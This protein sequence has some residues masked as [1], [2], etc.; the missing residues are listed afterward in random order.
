MFC[1]CFVSPSSFHHAARA[2]CSRRRVW[3]AV[4]ITSFTAT[5][6]ATKRA[7]EEAEAAHRRRA[8]AARGAQRSE[9]PGSAGTGGSEREARG[10]VSGGTYSNAI[11]PRFVRCI[12]AVFFFVCQLMVSLVLVRMKQLANTG[13]RP[14]N[15]SSLFLLLFS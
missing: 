10:M 4:G 14:V 12:S 5:I 13:L 15:V 8:R 11:A 7:F 2:R 1:D 9:L 3:N 6:E